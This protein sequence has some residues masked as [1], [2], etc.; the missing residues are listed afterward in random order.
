MKR[1]PERSEGSLGTGVPREDTVEGCHPEAQGDGSPHEASSLRLTL[2]IF[3]GMLK[4]F[5]DE[6]DITSNSTGFFF[7]FYKPCLLI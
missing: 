1:H 4:F 6:K 3:F 2:I 7:Y 5:Q